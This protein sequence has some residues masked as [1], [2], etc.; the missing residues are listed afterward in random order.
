MTSFVVG[1]SVVFLIYLFN[2]NRNP[3][4]LPLNALTSAQ[5]HGHSIFAG[6]NRVSIP[7]KLCKCGYGS[8]SK[9][10]I[11]KLGSNNWLSCQCRKKPY[12]KQFVQPNN[13]HPMNSINEMNG[14]VDDTQFPDIFTD[15]CPDASHGSCYNYQRKMATINNKNAKFVG[16]KIDHLKMINQLQNKSG[17]R[18]NSVVGFVPNPRCDSCHSVRHSKHMDNANSFY[19]F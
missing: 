19:N 1:G 15:N 5:L 14:S 13:T 2:K 10:E 17:R 7:N 3:D 18:C 4:Y 9:I 16:E 11:D 6:Y 12:F 8:E